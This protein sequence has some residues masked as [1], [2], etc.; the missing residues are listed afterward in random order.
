MPKRRLHVAMDDLLD[1]IEEQSETIVPYFNQRTGEVDIWVDPAICG[2]EPQLDPDAAD[3]VEI[4]RI[5]SHD[6]FRTMERFVD[7]LDELDVQRQLRT[8]LQGR[9]PFRRFRETLAPFP[10]LRD[11]FETMQRDDLLQRA[12][13]FLGTLDIEPTYELRARPVPV[14][15]QPA[16]PKPPQILLHHVLLLGAPGGKTELLEG[17]VPRVVREKSPARAMKLFERLAREIVELQGLGFRRSLVEGRSELELGPFRLTLDADVVRLSVEVPR[18]IWN[19][20][21]R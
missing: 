11:R 7:T 16:T 15:P 3:W 21:A 6:A 9:G 4:P 17:R 8:A 13:A 12:L 19:A 5:D 10:D 1:A 18:E 2:D 20:F 14:E